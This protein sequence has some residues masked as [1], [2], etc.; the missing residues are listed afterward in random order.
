MAKFKPGVS[1]NPRGRP[2]GLLDR[3]GRARQ[4]IDT[5]KE[6]LIAKAIQLAL[7]GDTAALK[8]CMERICAPIKAVDIPVLL[9]NLPNSSSARGEFILERIAAGSITPDEGTQL[10]AALAQHV[11]IVQMSEFEARLEVVE[12]AISRRMCE[13]GA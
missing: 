8:L 11:R 4:L 2:V 12:R 7:G 3:R 5:Q 1:G 6:Q 10:M 13:N 9:D